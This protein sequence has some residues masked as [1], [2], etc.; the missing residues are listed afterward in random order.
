MANA[1]NYRLKDAFF[2]YPTRPAQLIILLMD[3]HQADRL[4]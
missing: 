1:Y 4:G 2:K 3:K